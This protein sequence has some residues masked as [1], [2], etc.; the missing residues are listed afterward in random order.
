MIPPPSDTDGPAVAARYQAIISGKSTGI[1]GDQYYG[2]IDNL[3]D[4]VKHNFASFGCDVDGSRISLIRGLFNET[5]PLHENI[6]ISIAHIDCDWYDPV[7]Y[8][9]KYAWPRLADGGFIILDDYNDWPG[10]K[11]AAD[12]FVAENQLAFL[13]TRP[14][15]VLQKRASRAKDDA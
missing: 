9:L 6:V 10:C 3:Y 14:H 4:T 8:C 7:L 5:L 13:R 2:Y 12:E 1:S 15:A 11:K